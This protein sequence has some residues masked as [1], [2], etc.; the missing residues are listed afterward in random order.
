M[1]GDRESAT[2]F[3]LRRWSQRKH[4]AARGTAAA[5]ADDPARAGR[6]TAAAGEP[7]VRESEARAAV[8]RSVAA[9]SATNA[10]PSASSVAP[11]G[12]SAVPAE[13]LPPVESLTIDSD[14][15]PFLRPGVAEDLKRTALRKL[16]RDPRFNVMDGLDVYIDDYSKPSPLEPELAR[17]LLQARYILDPPKTRVNAQ[18]HVEDVP[19]EPVAAGNAATPAPGADEQAKP[20][21][22]ATPPDATAVPAG[23]EQAQRVAMPDQERAHHEHSNARDGNRERSGEAK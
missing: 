9:P 13:T 4:A 8:S 20:L 6:T 15:S 11:P 10:M 7:A 23:I 22:A 5:D 19:D 12:G 1:A 16:F 17:T 21:A 18:G 14:F 3:S 2:R